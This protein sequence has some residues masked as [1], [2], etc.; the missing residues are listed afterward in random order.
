MDKL[1]LCVWDSRI[2]GAARE[3]AYDLDST[4]VNDPHGARNLQLGMSSWQLCRLGICPSDNLTK[5]VATK[6]PTK[7]PVS[8]VCFSPNRKLWGLVSGVM[9]CFFW[10][11]APCVWVSECKVILGDTTWADFESHQRGEED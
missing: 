3:A 11:R 5:G 7:V 8:R 4:P 2:R 10:S 9:L 1:M 6:S